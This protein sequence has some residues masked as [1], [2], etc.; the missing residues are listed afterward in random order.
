MWIHLSM[1]S[2][3]PHDSQSIDASVKQ[4]KFG[5]YYCNPGD[6]N[7]DWEGVAPGLRQNIPCDKDL[8]KKVAECG[9][10]FRYVFAENR[11]D[12]SLCGYDVRLT[13]CFFLFSLPPDASGKYSRQNLIMRARPVLTRLLVD[14][15]VYWMSGR[16]GRVKALSTRI[17]VFFKT[18]TFSLYV[19]TRRDFESYLTVHT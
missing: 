15:S 9:Q 13:I 2:C 8:F 18:N 12:S 7:L 10:I 1:S 5:Q 16:C 3:W 4:F 11:S 17:R 6:L 14:S 19:S